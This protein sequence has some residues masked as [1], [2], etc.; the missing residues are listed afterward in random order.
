MVSRRK[1]L[2]RGA[3]VTGAGLA[4]IGGAWWATNKMAALR[5][6]QMTAAGGVTPQ[7]I[8]IPEPAIGSWSVGSESAKARVDEFFSFS[9]THCAAFWNN[10]FASVMGLI[11]KGEVRYVFHA[12]PLDALSLT[13]T[14]LVQ[15]VDTKRRLAFM[16]V[17]FKQQNA[18]AFNTKVDQ[19]ALLCGFARLFGMS[20]ALV[21]S[22]LADDVLKQAILDQQ[23]TAET[24]LNIMATPTFFFGQKKVVGDMSFSDFSHLLEQEA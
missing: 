15:N 2:T 23:K 20:G 14:M 13:A 4:G 9:C 7:P 24:E 21:K 17:L 6:G 8:V 11:D 3:L 18:W 10:Q 12:F 1:F 16:D 22:T 19:T 5:N